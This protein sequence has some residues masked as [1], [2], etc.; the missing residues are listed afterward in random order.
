[1]YEEATS[2]QV[3]EGRQPDSFDISS[4]AKILT[5]VN[6]HRLRRVSSSRRPTTIYQYI[7]VVKNNT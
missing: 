6:D 2:C 7:Y 4:A 5:P 1:M 3:L